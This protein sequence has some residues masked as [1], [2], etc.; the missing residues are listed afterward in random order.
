MSDTLVQVLGNGWR[1]SVTLDRTP[2]RIQI[3]SELFDRVDD[4]DTG[5]PLGVYLS[6]QRF[7]TNGDQQ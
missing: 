7:D 4:P 1:E 6:E 5:E 2:L 3:G